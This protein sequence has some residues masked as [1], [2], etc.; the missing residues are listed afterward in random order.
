[1][2]LAMGMSLASMYESGQHVLVW[3]WPSA[4]LCVT[5]GCAWTLAAQGSLPDKQ[6]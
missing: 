1:M 5:A 3:P 4:Q 6:V 2:R